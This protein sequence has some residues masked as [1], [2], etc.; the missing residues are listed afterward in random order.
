MNRSSS[1]IA[2]YDHH[3]RP[4]D[5][6]HEVIEGLRRR[7]RQI[8]PK[9]FYDEEGSRLFD[10]ICE[11]P[12][13]YPTR[14]EIALLRENATEM[15]Q[16]MGRGCL[17]VEPGS[18][19]SA[20][21]RF[22]LE[23]VRPCV[24]M[25]MDISKDYLIRSART[26]SAEYPWLDVHAACADFTSS[27]QLPYVPKGVHRVAFFPGS[28]IG[29]FDPADAV[30]FLS[31]IA[32]LVGKRG[33]LLIGVDLK[34]SAAILN[35]AYNDDQG[36]TA[37]FN[38]NLLKRI[39]RELGADFVLEGFEHR[40]FYNEDKGRIEMHLDSKAAQVVSIGAEHFTFEIGEGIHTENSYKYSVDEF[41]QLAAKAGL[42]ARGVWSDDE[43]LFSIHYLEVRD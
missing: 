37:A 22:L 15:A 18:G 4:A 5:F 12:E 6:Y 34:K 10:A 16:L 20:K 7:P 38:L 21:V 1:E 26:L 32:Q 30:A 27:V 17:L 42:V 28:S 40:A 24:Y 9:F 41:H 8:P 11:L 14:T 19:S 2:F 23:D 35:A 29:N 13:Y 33:G 36:V 25:P 39:N 3:P 43:E 31:N